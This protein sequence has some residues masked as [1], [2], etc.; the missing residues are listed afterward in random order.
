M[1]CGFKRP[2]NRHDFSGGLHL[3]ADCPVASREF[4]ERPSRYLYDT[5]IQGRLESGQRLRGNSVGDFVQ[6]FAYGDFGCDPRNWVSGGL[7][8]K[9]RT[10]ADTGVNLDDVIG[11]VGTSS[12]GEGFGDIGSRLQTHLYI[13]PAFDSQR[14]DDLQAC[15]TK[16]LIFL[17][18]KR[19]AGSNHDA[20]ACMDAH[21]VDVFHVADCDAVVG[22]VPHHL[23]LDLLP[24]NEG[25]FHQYLVDGAGC[26]AAFYEG[27]EIFSVVGDSAA[28]AS[29]GVG[30]SDDQR[31]ADFVQSLVSLFH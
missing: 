15:R 4:V 25:F 20:V 29:E 21:R 8:R 14:S 30:R 27:G 2:V 23:V 16:Q 3:S 7:G 12:T 11:A 26:Q 6:S 19:L 10:P 17:V 1:E 28:C 31:E 5:V 24:S 9:R 13:A 18:R 22:R